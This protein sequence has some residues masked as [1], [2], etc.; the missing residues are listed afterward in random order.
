V[1]PA[2]SIIDAVSGTWNT[3]VNMLKSLVNTLPTAISTLKFARREVS[4]L[5]ANLDSIFETF[6]VKG[7]AIF[8]KIASYYRTI[9]TVYFLCLLPLNLLILYYAFWAGGFFGGPEPVVEEEHAAPKSFREKCVL[10]CSSC[11]TF[12]Q[13]Y[14]DTTMCFWSVVIFM[15]IIVL[16]IFIASVA[17]CIIAGVKAFILAGC[18]QIYVLAD[19]TICSETLS[20]LRSFLTS[21]FVSD[22]TASMDATCMS[23]NLLTCGL[24]KQ[25]MANSTM[26]TTIFSLLATLFSL[27]LIM[28]SAVLHEQ[29]RWRRL[30]HALFL[31]E[32][33]GSEG[34]GERVN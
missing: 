11:S 3:M 28:N 33:T 23:D 7:P 18:D 34:S 4:K 9:W 21:F 31:K 17:L 20:N 13:K 5:S 2:D 8:D 19:D 25:K 27:Q 30:A 22:A 15:Q 29:A 6:E 10:C 14:H 1:N 32:A 16:L 24:I 12:L 26:L